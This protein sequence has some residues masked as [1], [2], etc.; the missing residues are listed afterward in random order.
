[1]GSIKVTAV[2]NNPTLCQVDF[3]SGGPAAVQVACYDRFGSRADSA[4]TLQYAD[5]VP[6]TGYYFHQSAYAFGSVP[7]PASPAVPRT[8]SWNSPRRS[9]SYNTLQGY[10]LFRYDL[11]KNAR[12]GNLQVTAE[13]AYPASCMAYSWSSGQARVAC[14][15][16]PGGAPADASFLVHYVQ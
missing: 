6:L 12:G 16:V 15:R 4:F 14:Y 11:P 13:G 2:G 10:Y 3:F 5:L 9:R 7:V 1:M 8:Y